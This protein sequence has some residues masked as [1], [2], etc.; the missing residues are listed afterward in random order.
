MKQYYNF[1]TLFITLRDELREFLHDI[2][3][4]YELSA[5]YPGYHFEI[6][7]TPS[8]AARINDF[9]DS[10]TISEVIA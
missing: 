10:V 5:C 8:E 3:V 2:G 1:E 9:I 6:Y 7:A 4:Y